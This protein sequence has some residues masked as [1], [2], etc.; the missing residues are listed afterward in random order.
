MK[1]HILTKKT[2]GRKRGLRKSTLVSRS[3]ETPS[4]R[5][6]CCWGRGLAPTAGERG[7]AGQSSRAR[8]SSPP[9]SVTGRP[10]PAAPSKE[11]SR[12]RE[13]N[14]EASAGSGARSSCRL[15]KGYFLN[16]GKLYRAAKEAVDRAGNFAYVGRQPQE[17]RLPPPLDHPHQRRRAR[18]R[19]VLQPVHRRPEAGR[20]RPRP[21]VAGRHRGPRSRRPSRSSWSRPRPRRRES[22]KSRSR[23]RPDAAGVEPDHRP[24]ITLSGP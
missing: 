21:Q 7:V 19:H 6:A 12:C 5:E 10:L 16:K 2:A 14:G 23:P 24:A 17:A 20:R 3:A 8:A 22:P 18:A 11:T 4:V 15:A 1:R 13:S 9:G